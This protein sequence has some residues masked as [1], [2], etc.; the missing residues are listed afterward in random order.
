MSVLFSE[1]AA[2][3]RTRGLEAG[4]TKELGT[5]TVIHRVFLGQEDMDED[6][7]DTIF[8]ESETLRQVTDAVVTDGH[9]AFAF[10]QKYGQELFPDT[11]VLACSIPRP[12]PTILRWYENV[13]WLPEESSIQQAV[14]LVFTLCP[15]TQ[16]VVGITDTSDDGHKRMKAVARAMRP[17][18]KRAILIFPGH[19]PGDDAGLNFETLGAVLSSVPNRGVTLFLG[20]SEDSAGR[21]IPEPMLAEILH[22]RT[23]SPTIVLD[24]TFLGTGVLGGPMISGK[25]TGRSAASILKR[26]RSGENPREM[27][28]QPIRATTILDGQALARFGLVAPQKTTIVNAP[29]QV[30]KKGNAIPTST[31]G[32]IVG[33]LLC[34]GFLFFS[35]R[36]RS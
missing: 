6:R 3:H 16:T 7:F 35:K 9:L 2:T 28:P 32:W 5:Q 33:L 10:A 14:D 31:L 29:N 22:T 26:L 12:A 24:D 15:Q 23:A 30:E 17:Y 11:P 20:V 4:L 25:S 36:H 21:P 19:E 13:L 18:Q 27:L 34:S 8:L 1:S